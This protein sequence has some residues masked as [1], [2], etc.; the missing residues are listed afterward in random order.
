MTSYVSLLTAVNVESHIHLIIGS[1][2]LAAA[3]CGQSL[4]AGA[5]PVLLAPATAELHYALQK[6]LDD[7]EIKWVKEVFQESHLLALGREDV[8]HVVDAVFV[9]SG[10]REGHLGTLLCRDAAPPPPRW[11]GLGNGC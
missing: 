3:R 6:R 2:S 4:A 11:T 8:D 10:S 1:N 5:S 9:T 7:G